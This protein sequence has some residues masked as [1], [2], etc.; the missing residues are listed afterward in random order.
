MDTKL[1]YK[2]RLWEAV[3]AH[4]GY[5]LGRRELAAL[6]RFLATASR[7]VPKEA[8]VLHLASSTGREVPSIVGAMPGIR[9][10]FLTDIVP[11]VAEQSC[12]K[13]RRSFPQTV[14][15][16][17]AVDVEIPGNISRLRRHLPG[18]AL[19]ALTGN[20]AIFSN[21]QMDNNILQ[22][23]GTDDLFLLTLEESNRLMF[24]SYLI[25]P[26]FEL[27]SQRG[28]PVTGKNVRIWYD[29]EAAEL[30]MACRGEDLLVS[31]KPTAEQLHRRMFGAGFAEVA[32]EYYGHLHMLA[33]LYRKR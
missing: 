7:L 32:V 3:A 6:I 1:L 8:D 12:E 21:H 13:M 31:Y 16:A 15:G 10:Y 27:L 19:I 2:D 4:P 14:F 11:E 30:H 23:M 17:I 9:N 5:N 25:A 24:K 18:P 26:V 22:A 28:Y 20:G 29:Q 33:G